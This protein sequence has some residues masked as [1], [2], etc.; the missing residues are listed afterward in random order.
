MLE[1]IISAAQLRRWTT[2][3]SPRRSLGNAKS[4]PSPKSVHDGS[5]PR[6][7]PK[8]HGTSTEPTRRTTRSTTAVQSSRSRRRPHAGT[9]THPKS[10]SPTAKR[11]TSTTATTAAKTSSN[12]TKGSTTAISGIPAKTTRNRYWRTRATHICNVGR[13][14]SSGKLTLFC[15]T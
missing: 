1:F 2:D 6:C 7:L 5:R 11:S 15:N 10:W 3:G 13:C 12:R 4:V 9:T 8:P 14:C